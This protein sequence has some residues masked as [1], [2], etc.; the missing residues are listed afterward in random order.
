[1]CI[2]TVITRIAPASTPQPAF[3][4]EAPDGPLADAITRVLH[5]LDHTP[6]SCT[7][8]VHIWFGELECDRRDQFRYTGPVRQCRETLANKWPDIVD[9]YN[10]QQRD[11]SPEETPKNAQNTAGNY[12]H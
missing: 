1:M 5:H 4:P 10:S 9:N 3:I 8:V 2:H 12:S 11:N 6:T 7:V